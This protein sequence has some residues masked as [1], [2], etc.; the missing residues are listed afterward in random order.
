[1]ADV[2]WV[3]SVPDDVEEGDDDTPSLML[4]EFRESWPEAKARYAELVQE[5]QQVDV[6]DADGELVWSQESQA[7]CWGRMS[8]P[9]RAGWYSWT[10]AA[11][12]VLMEDAPPQGWRAT[13]HR[14]NAKTK[15]LPNR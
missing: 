3:V 13:V 6:F 15:G 7:S 14:H 4:V 2:W 10:E 11:G 9:R 5:G 12:H 1:M 8:A